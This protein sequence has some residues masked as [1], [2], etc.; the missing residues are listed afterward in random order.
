MVDLLKVVSSLEDVVQ[1]SA[2]GVIDGIVVL[3]S[4]L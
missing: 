4:Q 3:L 2:W 1:V